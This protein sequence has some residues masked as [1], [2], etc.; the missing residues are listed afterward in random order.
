MSVAFPHISAPFN[1]IPSNPEQNTGG[2]PAQLILNEL[3]L[4]FGFQIKIKKGIPLSGGLG[5]SAASAVGVVFG[6]NQLLNGKL[7][8]KEMLQY[9]L[10]GEKISVSTIHADNIAPSLLG[11][12]TLVRDINSLDIIKIP[13]SD[14]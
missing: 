7:T 1:N 5:S 9:A 10:E 4:D 3:N 2:I 12:L 11:G 8:Q 6:I 14:S 13:I